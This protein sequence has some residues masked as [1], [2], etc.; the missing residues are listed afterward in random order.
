MN[1]RCLLMTS[2]Y[3]GNF[4]CYEALVSQNIDMVSSHPWFYST[5]SRY[6]PH[7]FNG[8]WIRAAVDPWFNVTLHPF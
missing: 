8:Q 7:R 6:Q 2:I 1:F 5:P 3:L 4:Q